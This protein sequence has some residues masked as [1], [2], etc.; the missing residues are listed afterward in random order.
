[1]LAGL[2]LGVAELAEEF[3]VPAELA[4]EGLEGELLAGELRGETCQRGRLLCFGAV[5][6]D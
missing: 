2:L 5:F 1:M 4:G 6:F 3:F